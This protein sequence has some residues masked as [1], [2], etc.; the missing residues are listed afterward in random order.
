MYHADGVPG[1]GDDDVGA[2]DDAGAGLL[3][4]VLDVV[5]EVVAEDAVV[6]RRR[7]LRV[8]PIQQYRRVTPLHHTHMSRL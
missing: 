4:R 7:L 2:G 8:W 3:E 5:D 1:R 6:L